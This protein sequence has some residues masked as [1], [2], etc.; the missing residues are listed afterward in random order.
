MRARPELAGGALGS[1]VDG[2]LARDASQ[3]DL[4]HL[5]ALPVGRLDSDHRRIQLDHGEGPGLDHEDH[6]VAQPKL[7]VG[8]LGSTRLLVLCFSSHDSQR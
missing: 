3:S 1:G 4:F 5:S 6:E 2:R 8:P 7:V